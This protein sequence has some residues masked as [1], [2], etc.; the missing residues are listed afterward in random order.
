[1]MYVIYNNDGSIKSKFLNEFVM[2][3]NN[4][5]NEVFVA[6]EGRE[7]YSLYATFK[8]P[9]GS[10]TTVV[11]STPTTEFIEGLGTFTGRK[12][13]L[14]NAETLV[15]GAL[16]MNV[17]CLDENDT[18]IVA[19]STYITVNETG[20]QLSDPVLLTV[21]EY[22]NLISE[23]KAKMNYP[24]KYAQVTALPD[25]PDLDT[26]YVLKGE[27]DLNE[28][29]M[30]NGKTEQWILIGS[31]RINLGNYYTKAEGEQFEEDINGEI[32]SIRS[33]VQAAAS[34]SPKGVYATLA[35]LQSAYP[36]GTN[37]IYV[38][39]ADGHWY[40]WDT[41]D[42]AW[43]DG[44]VYTASP[45]DTCFDKNSKNSIQNQFLTLVQ[46]TNEEKN[47]GW[48]NSIRPKVVKVLKDHDLR[49]NGI[50]EHIGYFVIFYE[51][52][53]GDTLAINF[54][55]DAS[56]PVS[57]NN[58]GTTVST[59]PSIY[60]Y[61]TNY[62]E[63]GK[64]D[65]LWQYSNGR[66]IVIPFVQS[67]TPNPLADFSVGDKFLVALC[68]PNG[69]NTNAQEY[70]KS[71]LLFTNNEKMF[72]KVPKDLFKKTDNLFDKEK[73]Y[74]GRPTTIY[75]IPQ[76]ALANSGYLCTP[77]IEIDNTKNVYCSFNGYGT[78]DSGNLTANQ[79][80]QIFDENLNNIGRDVVIQKNLQNGVR[81]IDIIND[82]PTA[83]Y[84]LFSWI[85]ANLDINKMYIT[86]IPYCNDNLVGTT[87]QGTKKP[88]EIN[89]KYLPSDI[90]ARNKDIEN[91]LN[92]CSNYRVLA[93]NG[94]NTRFKKAFTILITTDV[95]AD[96]RRFANAIE[97]L[98]AMP[99]IDAGACLG[100][101]AA[102]NYAESDGTWY[103]NL[104][105]QSNK[106]F[107]T[108]LGNHDCGNNKNTSDSTTVANAF[109]KWI[110]PTKT[111]IGINDLDKPYYVKHFND[112][113][114]SAIFLNIYD[115]P[116]TMNGDDFAVSRGLPNLQQTQVDWL[117][118]TL[119]NVP[120]DNAV[121]IFT[122]IMPELMTFT[123]DKWCA[124]EKTSG[125][126]TANWQYGSMLS[127][128][129]NAWKN[130][131]T[132]VQSYTPTDT[133]YLDTI[134]VNAD[135]T[136]RGTGKFVGYIAGHYH[137]DY[138]ATINA[139]T[140][141]YVYS[142]Y[143]TANDNAQAENNCDLP[144]PY[145]T[146]CEDSI[147]AVSIDTNNKLIKFTRIGSNISVEMK[148]RTYYLHKY[149]D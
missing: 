95:H 141:Q 8:L 128:I 113:K 26:I 30:F 93:R 25:N 114:L 58:A 68:F 38:V 49:N 144:R 99:Q 138:T 107:Y 131:T 9:N 135:F 146:K 45:S 118:S 40:Y 147:T 87:Q 15:A 116:D 78:G 100:D 21:Q 32:E 110:L 120:S 140:D 82:Y 92:A 22:E 115:T 44:G 124:Y 65:E 2:Q 129:L 67:R 89:E 56:T 62:V 77:L 149:Q 97:Y 31:N 81:G 33:E 23:I 142:F 121:V 139:H 12:I 11:S 13:L 132:L 96:R 80:A 84:V 35:D 145:G 6:I 108:I 101:I 111:K 85:S 55:F 70:K 102:N 52:T 109:I 1:M 29:Y 103:S 90:V 75:G 76:T 148:D 74:K 73:I 39:S 64:S 18:K 66:S 14:S 4:N 133:T 36:T 106:D 46:E 123:G 16:Q 41:N 57:F 134:N 98:N 105:L 72:S 117:I 7:D 63:K 60:F 51:C 19:F 42:S 104:V 61:D 37:G 59:N 20:I 34:G 127:D 86:Q 53:L 3:G 54:L 10:T 28:V 69:S 71:A 119:N 83:K 48:I 137:T 5:V 112:Y 91:V 17:V 24:T 126:T 27:Y 88:F 47:E 50:N 130:G 79:Y 143:C 94:S 122:H 125:T 136:L 43:T